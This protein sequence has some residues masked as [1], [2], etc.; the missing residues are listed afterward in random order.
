MRNLLCPALA[1][2]ITSVL[3]PLI[4]MS[5]GGALLTLMNRFRANPVWMFFIGAPICLHFSFRLFFSR[6]RARTLRSAAT[7]GR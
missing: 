6:L 3:Y 4:F 1:L 2:Q 7:N 5:A